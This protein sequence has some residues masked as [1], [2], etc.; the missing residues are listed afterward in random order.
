[1]LNSTF[2]LVVLTSTL[3]AENIDLNN[4]LQRALSYSPAMSIA[5][6]EVAMWQSAEYQTSLYPNPV[7]SVTVGDAEQFVG[8]SSS[9]KD[10]SVSVSQLVELGG[11]R[12]A[13]Q[14]G[15]SYETDLA[16]QEL[17]GIKLDIYNQ[18]V[19]GVVD[20]AS[21]EANVKMAK[22]R[23]ILAEEVLNSVMAKVEAGKA[24][25]LQ[26]NRAEMVFTKTEIAVEK[27]G[28]YLEVA[29]K[30]LASLWGDSE[31]D[32]DEVVFP[33]YTVEPL[34]ALSWL[35]SQQE[36]LNPDL[37]RWDVQIAQGEAAVA[38]EKAVAIP[39]LTI[40]AGYET[41]D[42]S[43][44]VGVA[45]PL[46]IFDRNQGNISRAEWALC[47]MYE[48]QRQALLQ[49]KADL[50]SAYEEVLAAYLQ[51]VAFQE[52]LL[53]SAEETFKGAKEGYTQGKYD[54]F[55]LLDAQ[56]TL[57]DIKQDYLD[58]LIEY[59]SHKAD[60]YRLVGLYTMQECDG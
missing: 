39:D 17:E 25:P 46:P 9:D 44:M 11:K 50:T 2:L 20:V 31:V 37:L 40:T 18:V 10:I 22:E 21:A 48:Q 32:F 27:A 16:I 1:M 54:Y 58:T 33:L 36:S 12:S 49:L 55:E 19:K 57:F 42:H 41:D 43:W 7:A 8:G 52:R 5:N 47:Q 15:A 23:Q 6:A 34:P 30:K 13:R 28:R 56:G 26:R 38:L 45:F 35:A 51:I 59:H 24:A 4:A 29:K 53:S 14:R 3:N 60:L